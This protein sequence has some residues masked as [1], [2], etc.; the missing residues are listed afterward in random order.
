MMGEASMMFPYMQEKVGESAHNH[1]PGDV[2]GCLGLWSG[3]AEEDGTYIHFL[4]T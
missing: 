4:M 1:I 3:N 2:L